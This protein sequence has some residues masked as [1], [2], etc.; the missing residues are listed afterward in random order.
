M[1]V[2]S[3]SPAGDAIADCVMRVMRD[4]PKSRPWGFVAVAVS[5]NRD[6]D[7]IEI[8]RHNVGLQARYAIA[9]AAHLLNDAAESIAEDPNAAALYGRLSAALMALEFTGHAPVPA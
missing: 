4:A 8:A 9:L 1:S 2:S 7:G 6:A 5:E 3:A